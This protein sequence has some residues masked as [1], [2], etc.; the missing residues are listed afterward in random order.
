MQKDRS[1]AKLH[2]GGETNEFNMIVDRFVFEVYRDDSPSLRSL[3][4]KTAEKIDHDHWLNP[5]DDFHYI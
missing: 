2:V 1:L 3:L 5:G 4:M